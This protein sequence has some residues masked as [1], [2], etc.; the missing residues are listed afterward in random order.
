MDANVE[1]ILHIRIK[2]TMA[3]LEKNN[4]RAFYVPSS[5]EAAALVSTLLEEGETV[6]T[7]GSATL[8]QTGIMEILRSGKYNFLDRGK[9][10]LTPE[11]TKEILHKALL[12]DTYLTSSN[13]ITETGVLYNV[14]GN[15]NRVAAMLYGPKRVIVVAG[16]NKIV[17]DLSAAVV[18]VK[19]T[20][21][22]A[23]CV[24]LDKDT[25]C[26]KNGRCMRPVCDKADLMT[27]PAGGCE[28][29]ICCN[30]VVMGRQR[31]ADRIIV[32]IVG[33]DLGF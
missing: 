33:E 27:L 17:P 28:D 21:A 13:A 15:S 30:S 20:A 4:M 23:N 31:N 19:E 6:A 10:G 3:A 22:P 18:R 2:R 1:R 16:Q 25:F 11:E 9:K 7:G 26:A 24:R 29:T 12:S 32:I 14:D 5:K 8:V